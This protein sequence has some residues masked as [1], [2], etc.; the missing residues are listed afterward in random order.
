MAPTATCGSWQVLTET[1]PLGV[2][3]HGYKPN[4]DHIITA[5]AFPL[6]VEVEGD[7]E[8]PLPIVQFYMPDDTVQTWD[9]DE[10]AITYT[11]TL[12]ASV[13]GFIMDT[14]SKTISITGSSGTKWQVGTCNT[15]GTLPTVITTGAN[16]I[17]Y[18]HNITLNN[19]EISATGDRRVFVGLTSGASTGSTVSLTVKVL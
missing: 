6:T 8:G 2:T 7:E 16:R 18:I 9:E 4:G 10:R 12:S 17:S 13:Q 19:Y 5:R 14:G 11:W 15:N 1:G 3:V